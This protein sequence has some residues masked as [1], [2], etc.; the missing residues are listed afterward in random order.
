MIDKEEDTGGE[1]CA[2]IKGA[3]TL[4]HAIIHT[5]KIG[6][7]NDIFHW[8]YEE[9][10]KLLSDLVDVL[11]AEADDSTVV[12]DNVREESVGAIV[13]VCLLVCDISFGSSTLCAP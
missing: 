10:L 6:L 4:A 13:F 1:D 5:G 2:D 7:F 3:S 8:A 12:D 11:L 9:I